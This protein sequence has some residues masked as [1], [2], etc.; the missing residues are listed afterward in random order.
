MA[1]HRFRVGEKVQFLGGTAIKFATSN[2]YEIQLPESNGEYQ[3]KIKSLD[4]PHLRVVKESQ[5]R[6]A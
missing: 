3:Y 6:R 4:E 1:T 2:V 5:L